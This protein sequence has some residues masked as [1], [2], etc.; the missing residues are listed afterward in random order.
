MDT[1][2]DVIISVRFC[3]GH[4]PVFSHP[5]GFLKPA[6]HYTRVD[7]LCSWAVDSVHGPSTQVSKMT[8]VLTARV[9]D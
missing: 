1:I 3:I 9:H 2:F 6:T 4:S 7:R 8:P 5:K